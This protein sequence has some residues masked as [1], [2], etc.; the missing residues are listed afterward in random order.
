[1]GNRDLGVAFQTHPGSQVSSRVEAKNPSLLSSRDGYLLE[2]T[3]WTKG[4]QA[5]ME[6]EEKS[7]D[8]SPG[9]A[10]NDEGP[11][12]AR[13]GQSRGFSRSAASVWG[14]S[15]GTT[16]S[17]GRLSWGTREV[18]SPCEGRGG[19][20]HCSRVMVGNRALKRVEEGLSRSFSVFRRKP[21]VP[22]TC[23]GD[24]RELLRV[25]L[26][27]QGYCGV[28]RGLSELHW[29]WCNGRGPHLQ[30]RQEPQG[31]SPFLTPIEGSLQSWDRETGLVLG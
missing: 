3:G 15:R 10:G 2:L 23:A 19:A 20:R 25:P 26:T 29:V 18:W 21:W 11:H 6:F 24:L 12:L 27:S 31:S 4:S 16:V 8:G 17:S 22:S 14:F 13:T 1:M 7:L 28:G 5:S 30:L 9:R